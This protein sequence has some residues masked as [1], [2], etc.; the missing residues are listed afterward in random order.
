MGRG[1]FLDKAGIYQNKYLLWLQKFAA[2]KA[3]GVLSL[4]YRK[5]LLLSVRDKLIIEI[6][7]NSTPA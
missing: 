1:I 4:F 7:M 3:K 5:T 6:T 2:D